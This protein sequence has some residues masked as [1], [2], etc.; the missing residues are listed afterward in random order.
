MWKKQQDLPII[1]EIDK[2]LRF[3]HT[4]PPPPLPN[5]ENEDPPQHDLETTQNC[6]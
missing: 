6:S 5:A 4:L 1:S 3:L 2:D